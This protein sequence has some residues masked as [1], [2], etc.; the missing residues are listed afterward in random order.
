MSSKDLKIIMIGNT[1]VGKSQLGN[2]ILG[3]DDKKGFKVSR[4]AFPQTEE[5]EEL[6]RVIEDINVTI[7]DTP[8]LIGINQFQ[9]PEKTI[10]YFKN[11]QDVDHIFLVI[12]YEV[13]Q[14][15]ESARHVKAD[16]LDVIGKELIKKLSII[17]THFPY[18]RPED[19]AKMKNLINRYRGI[20]GE[21]DIKFINVKN[22]K[23]CHEKYDKEIKK[24]IK[25]LF[26]K[27][28]TITTE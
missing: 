13:P 25:Q 3:L 1:G 17:A 20:F 23:I 7:V 21:I 16:L 10:N 4:S 22:N 27:K 8:G 5:I 15:E 2:F 6:T 9:N 28:T 18:D 24:I 26:E 11:N 12:N 14:R 19:K